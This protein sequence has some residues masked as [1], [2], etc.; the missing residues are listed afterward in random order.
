[1]DGHRKEIVKGVLRDKQG[2][3]LLELMIVVSIFGLLAT[4]AF[5]AILSGA[6][7]HRLN[8]ASRD[9]L[10]DMRNARQLAAKDN[11]QYAIRFTSAKRY[12]VV[13]ADTPLMVQTANPLIIVRER[14]NDLQGRPEIQWDLPIVRMPVF[15]ANGT[16]SSW[17]GVGVFDG[18]QAPN[19][20]IIR[21]PDPNLQSRTVT[22]SSFG[23]IQITIP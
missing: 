23:R 20:V 1:M 17:D 13:R 21:A 4:V 8:A 19:S 6:P 7:R 12:E 9:L 18:V 2:F 3:S 10:A 16:I 5:G 11:W 22:A 14:D 15:E